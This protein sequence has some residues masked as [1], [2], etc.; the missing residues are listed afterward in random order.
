MN[1]Q[2]LIESLDYHLSII[3]N[4]YTVQDVIDAADKGLES[5][6]DKSDAI[7]T[8]IY[9]K[10]LRKKGSYGAQEVA[11]AE[12]KK[13][14]IT[15]RIELALE[16]KQMLE[17]L[18]KDRSVPMDVVKKI[19]KQ[20]IPKLK[21]QFEIAVNRCNTTAVKAYKSGS[22]KEEFWDALTASRRLSRAMF[23]AGEIRSFGGP[24]DYSRLD[25]VHVGGF[26]FTVAKTEEEARAIMR[27]IKQMYGN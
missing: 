7:W 1:N 17:L 13:M 25:W 24:D 14:P 15:K 2:Q 19:A 4:N 6:R 16:K 23:L 20:S 11:Y 10:N 27:K 18:I 22:N 8:D 9:K 3:E 21:K 26:C 12:L 5:R